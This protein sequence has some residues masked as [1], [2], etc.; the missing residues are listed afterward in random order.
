[1]QVLKEYKTSFYKAGLVPAANVYFS[2]G[3]EDAKGHGASCLRK[4]VLA[5]EGPA[6]SDRG[7]SQRQ[8]QERERAARL[9]QVSLANPEVYLIIEL[10]PAQERM[11][12]AQNKIMPSSQVQL[13]WNTE[14]GSQMASTYTTSGTAC[15][16][17][18]SDSEKRASCVVITTSW[19]HWMLIILLLT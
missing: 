4:E 1:M 15:P 16:A 5:L 13:P 7:L 10:E 19:L 9:A 12:A 3:S 2:T 18:V 8:Q 17:H 14:A 6:P 11:H